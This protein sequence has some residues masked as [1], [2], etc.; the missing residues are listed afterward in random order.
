[1]Q[2]LYVTKTKEPWCHVWVA[3]A[4][5]PK[6]RSLDSRRSKSLEWYISP[7]GLLHSPYALKCK[8]WSPCSFY[9]HAIRT[10]FLRRMSKM[11]F[12]LLGFPTNTCSEHEYEHTSFHRIHAQMCA[13]GVYKRRNKL[14]KPSDRVYSWLSWCMDVICN[15]TENLR[16]WT[17]TECMPPVIWK[18]VLACW[19]YTPI[20]VICYSSDNKEIFAVQ[21]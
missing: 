21:H 18:A 15:E 9:L 12:C 11:G 10:L 19:Q 14:R 1:M 17:L 4:P 20:I 2:R 8:W 16:L 13:G 7:L 3:I 5:S 6:P